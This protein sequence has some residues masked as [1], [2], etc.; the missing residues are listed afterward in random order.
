MRRL[1][2]RLS[3][4]NVMS[5]LAVF[6]ALGGSSYA[7]VT[8]NGKNIKSRSIPGKKLRANSV[9][10]YEINES[11]LHT[12]ACSKYADTALRLDPV[13]VDELLLNCPDNTVLAAGACVVL[14][15]HKAA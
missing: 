8:L 5:T 11:R 2:R 10:G 1:L 9:T 14:V 12:V 3:Y 6:I 7:A 4:A 15:A 13:A